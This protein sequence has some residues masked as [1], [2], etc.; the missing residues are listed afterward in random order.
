[1]ALRLGRLGT[2]ESK[3]LAIGRFSRF[4]YVPPGFIFYVRDLTLVAQPFD[5][6]GLR[7]SGQPFPVAEQ[8]GIRGRVASDATF[9]VSGNGTIVTR[10]LGVVGG[11]RLV[12]RDRA[13]RA[14]GTLGPVAGLRR[15]GPLSGWPP[16]RDLDAGAGLPKPTKSG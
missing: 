6:K 11:R 2:T 12:W 4:E 14:L 13:G 15:R 1:V 3:V 16:G 8:V 5:A 7:L 10:A 9:S